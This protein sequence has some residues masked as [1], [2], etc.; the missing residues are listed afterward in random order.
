MSKVLTVFNK[1]AQCAFLLCS[2]LLTSICFGTQTAKNC[3]SA[4]CGIVKKTTHHLRSLAKT[5]KRPISYIVPGACPNPK[6]AL[7]HKHLSVSESLA[8]VNSI[9]TSNITEY[10]NSVLFN[11]IAQLGKPYLWGGISP[12]SGFDCSGLSQYV[13]KKEGIKIPRTALEQYNTLMPVDIPALGDLVFFKTH[14]QVVSH[15]GI[16]LGDGYFIHSPTSGEK[17]RIDTMNSGYWKT[18]YAGARRVI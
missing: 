16:Y 8:I 12:F 13:Y 17:I 3:H 4:S 5:V 7:H 6:A 15:V 1:G 9:D 2:L 14:G 11:A 18:C 10:Q